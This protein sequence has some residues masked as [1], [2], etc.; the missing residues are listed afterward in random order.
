MS[1]NG[2]FFP[3]RVL[4]AKG[5][6]AFGA[7]ALSD[8]ILEGCEVSVSGGSVSIGSGYIIIGGRVFGVTGSES[9]SVSGAYTVLYAKADTSKASS[10]S[11]FQQV[12]IA[13]ASASSAAAAAAIIRNAA[14]GYPAGD[15]N[16]A[17][18]AVRTCW[19]ALIEGSS[20]IAVNSACAGRGMVKI[21][22]NASPTSA[23]AADAVLT[24]P[25]AAAFNAFC[26]VCRT[27]SGSSFT[28]RS[29]FICPID[30]AAESWFNLEKISFERNGGAVHF[31]RTV[32]IDPA[33]GTFSFSNSWNNAG[34]SGGENMIPTAIY[35]F[36]TGSVID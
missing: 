33:A 23:F 8:G 18:D 20:V 5:L 2:I 27:T 32:T 19:L 34:F 31:T 21:W 11:S 25:A 4:T 29:A 3:G 35:G 14:S 1:I 12:T 30:S 10:T 15:L 13:A 17:S 26:I 9:G 22:E 36:H 28:G 24:I 16:G 7:G 6:G